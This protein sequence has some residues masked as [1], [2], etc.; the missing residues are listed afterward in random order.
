MTGKLLIEISKFSWE[1]QRKV[2][3]VEQVGH[4]GV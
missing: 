2:T 4:I 3:A 1:E